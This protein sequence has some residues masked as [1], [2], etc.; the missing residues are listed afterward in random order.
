MKPY[1]DYPVHRARQIACDLIALA[2]IVM[3]VRIGQWI[4]G[5][6]IQQQEWGLRME[7]AGTGFRTT[8]T[9]VGETLGDVPFIGDTVRG[10]FDVA[11]N[12]GAELEAAGQYQQEAVGNLA[13]IAGLMVAL[14]PILAVL[15]LWLI[16][17]LRFAVRAHHVQSLARS[18]AGLD[19][20]A[21]RAL[22]RLNPTLLLKTH[23][24]PAGAWRSQ[25]P[26]AIAE[27][28]HLELKASGVRLQ[29]EHAQGGALD[30]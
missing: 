10:P 1:S 23:P 24:D 12:A 16:P 25:E 26:G 17:R 9:D 22:T 29:G 7:E 3:W 8:M 15:A 5:Q 19:L 13:M 20:F 11:S 2:L 27:L 14:G 28:A 6:I 18:D 21:L 30:R 4:H